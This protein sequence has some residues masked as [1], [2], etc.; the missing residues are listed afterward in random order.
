MRRNAFRL[1]HQLSICKA[2]SGLGIVRRQ[3]YRRMGLGE[4]S[5]R[6][7]RCTGNAFVSTDAVDPTGEHQALIVGGIASKNMRRAVLLV[8]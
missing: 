3:I 8:Y 7:Q 6:V 5:D 1:A 2:S 4:A